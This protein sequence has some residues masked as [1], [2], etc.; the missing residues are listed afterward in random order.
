[1][2]TA[3]RGDCS[4]NPQ[5][6]ILSTWS[7]AKKFRYYGSVSKGTGT[8]IEYGKGFT[9]KTEVSDAQ[10]RD[11]LEHFSKKTIPVGTS[12]THPPKGSL[13]E[14][15]KRYVT[16]TGIASYVGPILC[17]EHLARKTGRRGELIE[18]L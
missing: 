9:N 3:R 16:Q 7:G 11:L 10:Y 15:L 2:A 4:M 12:H 14:W 8:Q 18:F 1:M 5:L 13:G 17:E 6:K